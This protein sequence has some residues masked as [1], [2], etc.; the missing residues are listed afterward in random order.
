MT[1]TL[2]RA[3]YP[4]DAAALEGLFA[5]YLESLFSRAPQHR[6]A[7]ETKY[8]ADQVP[9]LMQGYAAEHLTPTGEL[10]LAEIGS[11][12]VGMAMLRQLEAGVV[13]IQRVYVKLLARGHGLGRRLT[14][15]LID[16]ARAD[17]Q[18][19]VRLDTGSEFTEAIAL[20][21]GMGFQRRD[22]YRGNTAE[23]EDILIYFERK[24]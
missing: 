17:G 21:E 1:T 5:E 10:L 15:A 7:I 22:A 19:T 4:E 20:Y 6:A 18:H 16:K 13:E 23:L 24:L 3:R 11:T 14:L 2:R 12:P 8:P 9:A